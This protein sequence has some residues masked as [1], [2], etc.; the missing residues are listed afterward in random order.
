MGTQ[1][2]K[3]CNFFVVTPLAL[4]FILEGVPQMDAGNM[5]LF[6]NEVF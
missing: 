1:G 3:A 4:R 2:T 6:T 5:V